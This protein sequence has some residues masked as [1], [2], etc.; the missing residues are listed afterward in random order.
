M[1]VDHPIIS[2]DSH[3]SEAPNTY[4]DY[5]DPKYRD[6]APR[7]QEGTDKGALYIIDGVQQLWGNRSGPW[8]ASS[9]T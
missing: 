2:A 7:I 9:K 5:I 3:I 4:V 8:I 1:K 6:I